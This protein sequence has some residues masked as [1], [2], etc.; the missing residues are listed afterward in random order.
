MP[1]PAKLQDQLDT[2]A[3]FNDRSERIQALIGIGESYRQPD[4]GLV[5]R[6]EETKIPGCESEVYLATEP[7]GDGLKFRFAV[8]NPQG[9]SAMALAQI[10]DEG[11]SGEPLDQVKQV[12]DELVYEIFGRE[13]SMGK[14]LG[15]TNMVRAVKRR[16]ERA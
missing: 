3:M 7:I 13:L 2:L 16:A 10:L 8:D 1:I 6:T 5:P 9:I 11:L 4:A 12:P 14:S 15:L